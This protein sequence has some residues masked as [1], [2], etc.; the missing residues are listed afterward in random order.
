MDIFL[1]GLIVL[2]IAAAILAAFRFRKLEEKLLDTEKHLHAVESLADGTSSSLGN[3][4][5]KIIDLNKAIET[6]DKEH[7]H[8]GNLLSKEIAS[9]AEDVS[10]LEE[11]VRDLDE[12]VSDAC[13]AAETQSKK[14]KLMFDG[15]TSIMDYDINTARKAVRDD[16]Q[17]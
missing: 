12:K 10:A 2:A 13:E 5:L 6:N 16:A 4:C 8:D 1:Y 11:L 9:V 17:G 14:E 3:V 15:L 7:R